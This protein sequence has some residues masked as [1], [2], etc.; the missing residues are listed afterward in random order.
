MELKDLTGKRFGLWIVEKY[1]GKTRWRCRCDCGKTKNVFGN[2][3]RQGLSRSCGC[4]RKP[5]E[6]LTGKR[7]GLWTVRQYEGKSL[8][9]CQCDCGTQ[10]TI[11]SYS[12]ARG[13]T[14]SCGCQGSRNKKSESEYDLEHSLLG[15]AVIEKEYNT[16]YRYFRR[17][18]DESRLDRVR[19]R[20][21]IRRKS[22]RR[23]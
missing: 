15:D 19:E 13:I 3:L 5:R 23:G 14:L 16:A 6:D 17:T 7:F 8:W 9:R 2:N 1:A 12:L 18:G 10:R 22:K 20:H 4:V 11:S 21:G